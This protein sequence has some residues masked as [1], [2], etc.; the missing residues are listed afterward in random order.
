MNRKLSLIGVAIS[1]YLG[2]P[3]QVHASTKNQAVQIEGLGRVPRHIV[4]TCEQAV[5]DG[6]HES[7]YDAEWELFSDCVNHELHRKQ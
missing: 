7:F 5:G 4:L 1:L 3:G 6:G 2:I